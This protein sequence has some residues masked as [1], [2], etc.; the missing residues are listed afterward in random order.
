MD[1]V[2]YTKGC[3]CRPLP[4][5]SGTIDLLVKYNPIRSLSSSDLHL[6]AVPKTKHKC[7]GDRAFAAVAPK[8]WNSLPLHIKLY[9]FVPIFKSNLKTHLF[10]IAFDSV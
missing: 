7:R 4:H 6:L 1:V 8:L 5:T 9:P 3:I 2:G 10:S